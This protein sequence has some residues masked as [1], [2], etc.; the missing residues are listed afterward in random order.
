MLCE[1]LLRISSSASYPILISFLFCPNDTNVGIE[2]FSSS[3]HT[4]CISLV[5][6]LTSPT[7]H[8]VFPNSSPMHNSFSGST[9]K[10]LFLFVLM[11]FG[12]L[13][14]KFVESLILYVWKFKLLFILVWFFLFVLGFLFDG[15]YIIFNK[16]FLSVVLILLSS[17]SLS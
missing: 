4:N 13:K 11:M 5:F 15:E 14:F 17:L 6:W 1:G 10:E 8:S 3:K 2:Y 7:L 16:F 12:G 9:K